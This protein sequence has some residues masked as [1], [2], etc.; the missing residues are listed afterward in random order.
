MPGK[1]IKTVEIDTHVCNGKPRLWRWKYALLDTGTQ[2]QCDDC[3]A[4]WELKV[5]YYPTD[6]WY[7]RWVKNE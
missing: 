3:K 1:I 7:R 4:I 2:W 5:D 6:G